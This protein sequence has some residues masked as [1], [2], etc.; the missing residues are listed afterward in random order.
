M[1]ID[2]PIPSLPLS[3]FWPCCQNAANKAF[4]LNTFFFVRL[5][6]VNF[7]VGLSMLH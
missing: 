1:W 2:Y 6:L 4:G 7:R 3:I 5:P